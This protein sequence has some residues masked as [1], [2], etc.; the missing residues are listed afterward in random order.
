MTQGS[1]ATERLRV[2]LLGLLD[3]LDARTDVGGAQVS[4]A[5]PVNDEVREDA[6]AESHPEVSAARWGQYLLKRQHDLLATSR[7]RNVV[8]EARGPLARRHALLASEYL[9]TILE[10]QIE[11]F[12]G[13]ISTNQVWIPCPCFG[14]VP[15]PPG[16]YPPPPSPPPP[17]PGGGSACRTCGSTVNP[18]GARYCMDCGNAL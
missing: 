3:E 14:T 15:P 1:D 16:P 4:A 10:G 2:A 11:H 12:S 5:G 6:D 13:G 8:D 17:P 7:D 18:Q 9:Q